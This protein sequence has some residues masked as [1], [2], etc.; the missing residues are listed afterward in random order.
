[1]KKISSV[2]LL[3]I[4]YSALQAQAQV[5]LKGGF[6]MS[7][8]V[9]SYE[10]E[11]NY[12]TK[13]NFNAGIIVS[14]PMGSGLSL[15]PEM[16]YSGEGADIE[17][18][19]VHGVY[20]F[21]MLNVPVLLKYTAPFHLFAETGPQAGFLL[22]ATIKEGEFPST[23]VK[24]QTKSPNYSWAFG[25]GYQLPAGLGLDIRYNLGLTD[26]AKSNNISYNDATVKSNVFQIGIYFLFQNPG[27]ANKN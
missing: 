10:T 11:I 19:N 23:N 4:S 2:I 7:S 17:V 14:L 25:V 13:T 18:D 24:S 6:N 12:S 26:I 22:G 9:A 16:Y 1:M 21:Q 5:G 8:F 15:Q 3:I 20:S 27:P